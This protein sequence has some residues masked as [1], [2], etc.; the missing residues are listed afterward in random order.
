MNGAV[1]DYIAAIIF[2]LYIAAAL[3]LSLG[4]IA[5]LASISSKATQRDSTRRQTWNFSV[6]AGISFATL[7]F[8]MLN[9]LINS[10]LRWADGQSVHYNW[11][12][13]PQ[14]IWQWSLDT[15]PFRDFVLDIFAD[16]QSAVA[17]AAA[18]LTTMSL[19]VYMGI[20]GRRYQ[21]P[22]LGMFFGLAQ[23]LPISFSSTL[24]F[25]AVM[26]SDKHSAHVQ[27]RTIFLYTFLAS[28]ALCIVAATYLV[29]HHEQSPWLLPLVISAR[30]TLLL[31]LSFHGSVER[32]R[33]SAGEI[34]DTDTLLSSIPCI[35]LTPALNSMGYLF[36]DGLYISW[37][38]VLEHPAVSTLTCDLYL[39]AVICNAWR[40]TK[41]A[42]ERI[43]Q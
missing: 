43:K 26:R 32:P 40:S 34:M 39:A 4:V 41:S 33:S 5:T 25:I 20:E 19:C 7:S 12:D 30:L 37:S 10:F 18:L 31:P 16:T 6:L 13:L 14:S 24:F 35:A 3:Y 17:S 29:W 42:L 22:N 21:I 1:Q 8:N 36:R 11:I 23:I 15:K 27:P 9:I 38:S 28:F 2:W